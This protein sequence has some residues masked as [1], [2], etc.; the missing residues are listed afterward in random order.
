MK[1]WDKNTSNQCVLVQF[2]AFFSLDRKDPL[3]LVPFFETMLHPCISIFFGAVI[4]RNVRNR[5]KN[6]YGKWFF[7]HYEARFCN[8]KKKLRSPP[9]LFVGMCVCVCVCVCVYVCMCVCVC[10]CVCAFIYESIFLFCLACIL[11]SFVAWFEIQIAQ[12]LLSIVFKKIP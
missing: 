12:N 4:C 9:L 2:T 8:E 6:Y 3:P 7:C 10:V 1:K 5:S 11:L